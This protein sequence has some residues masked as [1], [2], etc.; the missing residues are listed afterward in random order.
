VSTFILFWVFMLTFNLSVSTSKIS[1]RDFLYGSIM[2]AVGIQILQLLGFIILTHQLKSL[3]LLYG[4]FAAVLGIL[5]WIYLQV[6]VVLYAAE[7]DTVRVLK[8]WPRS[9]NAERLTIADKK[10]YSLYAQKERF[11]S[12]PPQQ[13]EVKFKEK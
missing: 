7:I 9:L 4:T 2:A 10:A 11:L 8:L 13:V 6:Q 5:F 3:S 12:M 1:Y